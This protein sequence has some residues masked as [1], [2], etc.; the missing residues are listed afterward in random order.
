MQ[1]EFSI[2]NDTLPEHVGPTHLPCLTALLFK[3]NIAMVIFVLGW[4]TAR[5]A[6]GVI[7]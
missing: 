4:M 6:S 1:L 5:Q 7:G 3:T 2:V